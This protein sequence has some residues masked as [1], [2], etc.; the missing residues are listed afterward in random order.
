[1]KLFSIF[2]FF[3][4]STQFNYAQKS[5]DEILNLKVEFWPSFT[6]S[7]ILSIKQKGKKVD[8][9]FT[10]IRFK[11]YY[12]SLPGNNEISLY[13]KISIDSLILD[14]NMKKYINSDS[15]YIRV[16]EK[17]TLEDKRIINRLKKFNLISQKS[18]LVPDGYAKGDGIGL[19]FNYRNKEITNNFKFD[20]LRNELKNENEFMKFLFEIIF[21]NFKDKKVISY[22]EDISSYFRFGFQIKKSISLNEEY[23]I[24]GVFYGENEEYKKLNKLLRKLKSKKAFIIDI[25]NL[26][27]SS[28]VLGEIEEKIIKKSLNIYFL[29]NEYWKKKLLNFDGVDQTK[30]FTNEIN[31]YK[32]LKKKSR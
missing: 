31:L 27:G 9:K 5:N 2:L 1:M 21:E 15:V 24:F 20:D 28:D 17:T 6:N 32:E 10:E 13:S 16:L 7:S 4:L 23:R 22:F 30:V 25:T 26:K 8:L 19:Y 29:V 11:G 12:N 3:C 18:L 14:D